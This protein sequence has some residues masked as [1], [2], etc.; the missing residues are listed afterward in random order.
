MCRHSVFQ[1]PTGSVTEIGEPKRAYTKIGLYKGNI[2]A[3]KL[4]KKKSVDLTR[5]IRKE[6]KQVG[7]D[8]FVSI[9]TGLI[10]AKKKSKRTLSD[11]FTGTRTENKAYAAMQQ[12]F[13][14]MRFSRKCYI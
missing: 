1:A 6:L 5:S 2:V 9:N 3:I 11:D 7:D 4:L 14:F 12:C 13:V 8:C 10:F